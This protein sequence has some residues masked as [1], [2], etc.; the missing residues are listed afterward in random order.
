[1]SG[2]TIC[3]GK[4]LGQNLRVQRQKGGRFEREISHAEHDILEILPCEDAEL[5]E[6]APPTNVSKCEICV[7]KC[8]GNCELS[9]VTIFLRKINK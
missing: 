9:A 2:E 7:S 8:E 5:L 6:L 3:I 4:K 1:M